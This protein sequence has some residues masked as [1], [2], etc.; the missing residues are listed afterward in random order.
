[1]GEVRADP[2]RRFVLTH[3]CSLSNAVLFVADD[4]DF[5][6]REGVE[7]TLPLYR[8]MDTPE[9]MIREGRS[10]LG[11]MSFLGPMT[12]NDLPDR[13]VVVCGSGSQG[14][15]LLVHPGIANAAGLRGQRVGTFVND[16]LQLLLRDYCRAYQISGVT[17]T[18][19]ST[20]D[21]AIA[22]FQSGEI[23]G[24][25][26]VEPYATRLCESGAVELS[27]G[28]DVWGGEFPDTVFVSSESLLA[29]DPQAVY[30]A[31][32]ALRHAEMELARDP[33]A[34]L[35]RVVT[36]FPG[37]TVDELVTALAKTPVTT[38][39]RHLER[40]LV[41]RWDDAAVTLGS[42]LPS[43][44]SGAPICWEPLELVLASERGID[45]REQCG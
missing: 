17:E 13:P 30:S 22:C 23:A 9:T 14:V 27:D 3:G 1:M 15:S 18:Y 45:E 29:E 40:W 5:F 34:A 39:I 21:E 33:R 35:E 28:T 26:I 36:Q 4:H 43:R 42:A 32:R 37:Y 19:F 8:T 24:I 7:V 10:V 11:T 20:L 2:V 12:M 31:I 16:P 38:D 44:R 6:R 41:G 25:T